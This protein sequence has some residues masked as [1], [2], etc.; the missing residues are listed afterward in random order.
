MEK[1][2]D[3]LCCVGSN[4]FLENINNI[5]NEIN[6][7]FQKISEIDI[8]K[9]QVTLKLYNEIQWPPCLDLSKEK[10]K[11]IADIVSSNPKQDIVKII[12]EEYNEDTLKRILKRWEQCDYLKKERFLIL[13]EAV[14]N[15]IC[16]KYYSCVVLNSSQY[17]GII[18]D[19]E[20][21][22][23]KYPS[24]EES[25]NRIKEY[26]ELELK[27][28]YNQ[29]KRKQRTLES[30]KNTLER[31]SRVL[32]N[33]MTCVTSQYFE[34]YIYENNPQSNEHP[35]RHKILHGVECEFGTQEKAL[36]TILCIDSLIMYYAIME[37]KSL[38]KL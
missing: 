11:E 20:S 19:I 38:Y 6:I 37:N 14:D 32:L 26:Q 10:Q 17:G 12:L 18:N 3:F 34:N 16:E 13:K 33:Y 2:K 1:I 7:Y 23:K 35:N 21:Y 5:A 4:D 9:V 25:I 8:L 15:Y 27:D 28:K 30:E 31:N 29:P 22:L 36:K 24:F